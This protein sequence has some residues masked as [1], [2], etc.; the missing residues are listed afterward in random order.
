MISGS[1][2]S[3][4]ENRDIVHAKDKEDKKSPMGKK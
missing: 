2:I 4:F 3:D 1:S